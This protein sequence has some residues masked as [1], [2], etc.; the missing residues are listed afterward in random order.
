MQSQV[1]KGSQSRRRKSVERD[2]A[3]SQRVHSNATT[4][5]LVVAKDIDN[6]AKQVCRVVF[7][8]ICGGLVNFYKKCLMI[9]RPWHYEFGVVSPSSGLPDLEKSPVFCLALEN[10]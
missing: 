4:K 8:H 3:Y 5:S 10:V 6:S 1:C 7:M 2:A 9:T